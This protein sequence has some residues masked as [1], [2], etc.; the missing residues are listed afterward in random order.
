[1]VSVLGWY[2]LLEDS[3]CKAKIKIVFIIKKFLNKN[4][5]FFYKKFNE[6]ELNKLPKFDYVF[7]FGIPLNKSDSI[8]GMFAV[9]GYEHP[10]PNDTSF[11]TL[12]NQQ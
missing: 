8:Y 6:L 2:L 11:S 5:H 9:I 1:M 10:A 4:H 3:K 7:L 12:C